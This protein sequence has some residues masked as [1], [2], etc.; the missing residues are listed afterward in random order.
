M[1]PIIHCPR[2]ARNDTSA[3]R[4]CAE[5]VFATLVGEVCCRN[6]RLSHR[7]CVSGAL[8]LVYSVR[9]DVVCSAVWVECS[10]PGSA[11]DWGKAPTPTAGHRLH[12]PKR[13][14]R[15]GAT[16]RLGA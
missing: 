6:F 2:P 1:P 14:E 13:S 8:S 7:P 9:L 10:E 16:S 15:D 3:V 12:P 11:K 5:C 4:W